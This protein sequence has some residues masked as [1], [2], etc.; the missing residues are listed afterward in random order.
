M[1]TKPVMALSRNYSVV[2]SSKPLR[3]SRKHVVVRWVR[4]RKDRGSNVQTTEEVPGRIM[5]CPSGA[6]HA[7]VLA[8][9]QGLAHVEHNHGPDETARAAH[10]TILVVR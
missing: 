7:H 8:S 1:A 5:V 9:E 6:R 10:H 3:R 4:E 2:K